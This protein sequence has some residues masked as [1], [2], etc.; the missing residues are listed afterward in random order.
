MMLYEEYNSVRRFYSVSTSKQVKVIKAKQ[1]DRTMG[2]TAETLRVA[3]YVRVSTTNEEQ[4]ESFKSQIQYFRDKITNNP[5]WTLVD[6]YADEGISGTGTEKR[7]DF[8]R[9]INDCMQGKIDMIL[10]KSLSRFSRNVVDTL[11]YV[12]KLRERNIAIIFEQE[13]INTLESI[14]DVLLIILS[15]INEQYVG[16]LSESVKHGLRAKMLRGE[17]VGD[18]E[19]LG[20]DKDD[21]TGKLVINEAEAEIVRYIFKRYAEGA[22]GRVIGRELENLGYKTKRG[23]TTWGESTVL[24][25]IKN[26]KY[27]GDLVQGKTLTVDPITHRRIENRGEGDLFYLENAH[28][29]IIDRETWDKAQAILKHRNEWR[30]KPTEKNGNKYSRKHAFSCMLK[31][32]FCG[33]NLSRRSHHSGT[34]HQKW[35]WHCVSYTKK[36]KQYCPECKAVDEA[37][38]EGAFVQSYNLL[39]GDNSDVLSEFLTR[40]DGSLYTS[41]TAK[42]LAKIN[43]QIQS[44][45]LKLQRLLDVLLDGTITQADYTAKK[46]EIDKDLQP[47]YEEQ[48]A[49]QQTDDDEQ[50]LK[51]QLKECKEALEANPILQE[52]DRRVFEAVIDHVVIGE[53]HEDGTVDPRKITFVFK[54]GI[55]PPPSPP[56]SGNKTCSYTPDNTRGE[57]CIDNKEREV[58]N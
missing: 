37:I 54:S 44:Y 18:P 15:A 9:M 19:A 24:G 22:G 28:S 21:E 17:H 10:T 40:L 56:I 47:L 42:R 30:V 25:I 23:N 32:G 49:L 38:I 2:T 6:I 3:A 48:K 7:E 39:A 45:E 34:P 12:R 4:L 57:C 29:A 35:V 46:V 50:R 58:R 20:Y 11:K 16:N 55:Q 1:A 43:K 52:F 14:G 33:H 31:C 5:K 36:G 27:I 51:Q 26:E 53:R 8:N 41:G 13:G